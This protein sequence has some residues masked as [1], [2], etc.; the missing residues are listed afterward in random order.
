MLIIYR[1]VRRSQGTTAELSKHY[2]MVKPKLGLQI[3]TTTP[4]SDTDY[5]FSAPPTMSTRGIDSP[6]H[7]PPYAAEPFGDFPIGIVPQSP[8]ANPAHMSSVQ[9]LGIKRSVLVGP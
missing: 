8:S 7:P 9:K 5:K 4:F 2:D 6:Y 3:N 1:V